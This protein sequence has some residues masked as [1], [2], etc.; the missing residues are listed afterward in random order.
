MT[1]N[2]FERRNLSK[3]HRRF[4]RTSYRLPEVV[5]VTAY[6]DLSSL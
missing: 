5:R 6:E 2:Y 3:M 4:P 1:K